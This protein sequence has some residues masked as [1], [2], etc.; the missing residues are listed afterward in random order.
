MRSLSMVGRSAPKFGLNWRGEKGAFQGRLRGFS[1]PK[2][3][4][5]RG[6]TGIDGSVP[7]SIFM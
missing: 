2:I 3:G 5:K 7:K 1:A 6:F 4:E